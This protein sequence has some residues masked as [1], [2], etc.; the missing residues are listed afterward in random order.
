MSTTVSGKSCCFKMS[1]I[2]STWLDLTGEAL[3]E[4]GVV[5][6]WVRTGKEPR[7]STEH[8]DVDWVVVIGDAKDK[9]GFGM[10]LESLWCPE[11][12]WF[13]GGSLGRWELE[14]RHT[15]GLSHPTILRGCRPP[16]IC[17]PGRVKCRLGSPCSLPWRTC[18]LGGSLRQ[19]TAWGR[20]PEGAAILSDLECS[21]KSGH[22]LLHYWLRED[23]LGWVEF[24][25]CPEDERFPVFC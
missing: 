11:S 12:P 17:R 10:P 3:G 19:K 2:M 9:T 15:L 7:W 22:R 6:C 24:Q 13:S 14:G 18:R 20:F 21:D 4:I 16:K 23:G 5:T 25:T 1:M 8:E